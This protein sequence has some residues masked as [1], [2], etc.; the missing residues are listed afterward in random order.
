MFIK[1][2]R[3]I[4]VL[5]ISVLS[6]LSCSKDKTY[7]VDNIGLNINLKLENDFSLELD[8][9][10]S[11]NSFSSFKVDSEFDHVFDD[12]LTITFSSNPQ[13]YSNS[14]TFDPSDSQTTLSLPFGDYDW[15]IESSIVSGTAISQ[16]LPVYGQSNASITIDQSE[17]DLSLIVQTDYSLVT[18]NTD[19]VSSVILKHN[20]Q[21]LTLESKDGFFYGYVYSGATS[22]TLEVIDNEGYK[23]IEKLNSVESCKEYKYTL[24][25]SDIN[26]NSLVCL[27]EPFEV[28]ETFLTPFSSFLNSISELDR[29]YYDSLIEN[30]QTFSPGPEMVPGTIELLNCSWAPLFSD[31]QGNLA[32]AVNASNQTMLLSH[33]GYLTNIGMEDLPNDNEEFFHNFVGS[34][35]NTLLIFPN[36]ENDD[37]LTTFKSDVY[38]GY[39]N[40][41]TTYFDPSVLSSINVN[42]YDSMI[43][44]PGE[45]KFTSSE[46]SIIKSFIQDPNKKSI[47]I[48]LGWV[49]RDYYAVSDDDPMPIN[50]ILEDLG[51][52][53]ITSVGKDLTYDIRDETI[54]F[55]STID[56]MAEPINCSG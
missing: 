52:R 34:N 51:A 42:Q 14:A 23:I 41:I 12:E 19:H 17:I 26:V 36:F 43:L 46:A 38:I 56:V 48:G 25:Y 15:E 21:S 11:K 47:I 2:I 13:G 27:C 8:K 35:R 7:T 6:S 5:I 4:P 29:S 40:N 31:N 54:F 45:Y 3:I 9:T 37:N 24:N 39:N 18:V 1:K 55:P 33:E 32:G 49:W 22:F 53:Y 20:D 28:I 30:V 44:F 50:L 16:K 10:S